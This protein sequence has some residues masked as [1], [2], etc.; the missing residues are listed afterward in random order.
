MSFASVV[1]FCSLKLSFVFGGLAAYGIWIYCQKN[2]FP[3]NI[4]Q[5]SERLLWSNVLIFCQL[6]SIV[7]VIVSG[8][9]NTL[10]TSDLIFES[11]A[12]FIV[13]V[14]AIAGMDGEICL[15]QNVHP[16]IIAVGWFLHSIWIFAHVFDCI[17]NNCQP[18]WFL[19]CSSTFDV[20]L[21][22]LIYRKS[23]Q[24]CNHSTSETNSEYD[25]LHYSS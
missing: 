9:W 24:T 20:V 14:I 18:V 22:F 2:S 8:L 19:R 25:K 23:R 13:G 11:I 1:D 3:S 12:L 16:F 7:C 21:A 10:S 15:I 6:I 4:F 5:Y 17:P